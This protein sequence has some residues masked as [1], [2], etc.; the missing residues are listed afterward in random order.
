VIGYA[1]YMLGKWHLGHYSPRALPTARGF[2]YYLGFLTGETHYWS[3]KV[4]KDNHYFDLLESNSSCKL[5]LRFG[6][7]C[8]HPGFIHSLF[9]YACISCYD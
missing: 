4:P 6:F 7:L 5:K 3:K 9:T 1:T 2:D 8:M